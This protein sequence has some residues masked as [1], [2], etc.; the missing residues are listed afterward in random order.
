[1]ELTSEHPDIAKWLK[2]QQI[3]AEN[4]SANEANLIVISKTR[5]NMRDNPEYQLLRAFVIGT[6][7]CISID[8]RSVDPIHIATKLAE[9]RR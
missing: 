4:Y 9:M 1:M 3:L 6:D 7:V 8:Q 5:G 2:N